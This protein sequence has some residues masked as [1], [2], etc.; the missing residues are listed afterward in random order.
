M[1]TVLVPL[2]DG[3]EEIEAITIIDLLRRAGV[4]VTTASLLGMSA[5][6]AH[7]VTITAD[8]NLDDAL[9]GEYDM[10]VLP[11]GGVGA[12]NL[13]ADAR[14]S[15]ALKKQAAAGK[16]TCA[17]CAAPVVLE[18]AG[19]LEG[20]KATCYPGFELSSANN[21][22]EA[23]E[24]D[25]KVVTGRGPGTAMDFALALIEQLEGEDKRNEIEAQLVRP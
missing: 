14:I 25:G 19:L 9:A 2:A 8:K 24:V 7:D 1:A 20:K 10:I 4:D 3:L 17:I 16:F 22:G 23:V 12:Q 15:T 21:T 5:R 13:E 18:H 6:G 11:G